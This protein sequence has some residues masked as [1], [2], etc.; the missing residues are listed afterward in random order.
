MALKQTPFHGAHVRSGAKLVEFAG[1]EMPIQYAGIVE[2]HKRVR[3]SVGVFDVS[4]MGEVE[5]RGPGA[6]A[7]VQR[8]TVND[9]SRLVEGRVQYSA[10]CYEDGGIVDDLLV[11]H[12]GDHYMLVINASNTEK[13]IAWMRSHATGDVTINDRSESTGLL[14][15]QGPKSLATLQRLTDLD[16]GS[17][18]Y[19]HWKPGMIAG[20]K[21]LVSRTGYTG[22]LGFELYVGSDPAAGLALWDAVMEAGREHEIGP[23]GLGA[24]DTLR[25]EMGFCLYGN[26]IDRTTNPLEAGLG[27]ITKLEK[28]DFIGRQALQAVKQQGLRRKLV[29]FSLNDR[30]FPRHGYE[31]QAGGKRIGVVTS[32]TFSPVLEKGIGMGYVDAA[33]AASGSA[34]D[35]MVRDRCVPATVVQLPFIRK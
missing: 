21:A 7:F 32:G 19:Y 31:I 34:L 29:G 5:V 1:F 12:C 9:A 24:R 4:H 30:A 6:L 8:I 10:M 35:I 23:V 17:I 2:E 26:D 25:L 13:D 3:N 22:E 28:G 27:W 33:H 14:A 11:Y 16:L 15:V 18:Q 20:V